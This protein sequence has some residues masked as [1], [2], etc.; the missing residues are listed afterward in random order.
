MSAGREALIGGCGAVGAAAFAA[1]MVPQVLLNHRRVSTEGLS[2]GLVLLWHLAGMLYFAFAFAQRE[3]VW[4][5]VSMG[6]FLTVTAVLE[7]QVLAYGYRTRWV[8]AQLPERLQQYG[9]WVTAAHIG[10]FNLLAGVLLGYVLRHA[11]EPVVMASG[12]VLPAALFAAGFVPQ[13]AEFGRSWSVEGYSF[14]V[15]TFDV[16]GSAANMALIFLGDG[17]GKW[18]ASAPFLSIVVM[19]ALLLCLAG[20]IVLRPRP[21]RAAGTDG[22]HPNGKVAHSAHQDARNKFVDS[23]D[24]PRRSWKPLDEED[25]P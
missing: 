8:E 20:L 4:L 14:L 1:M 15:T 22:E 3:S 12:T 24:G 10:L 16:V 18:L 19:H 7:A 9:L 21:A 13:L 11:P 6:S 2:V 5:L 25:A 23:A 17:D